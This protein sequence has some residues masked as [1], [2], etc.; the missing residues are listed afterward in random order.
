[1]FVTLIWR[2]TQKMVYPWYAFEVNHHTHMV[3]IDNFG[4]KQYSKSILQR[5]GAIYDR[6]TQN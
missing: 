4:N 5:T 3:S 2:L 1:M 6:F